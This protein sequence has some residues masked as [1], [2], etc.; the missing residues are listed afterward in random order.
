MTTDQPGYAAV[1]GPVLGSRGK[2]LVAR[3]IDW[4]VL[5]VVSTVLTWGQSQ[6]VNEL[7]A[8]YQ[9]SSDPMGLFSEPEFQGAMLVSTLV[10]LVLWVV[11]EGL[12]IRLRGAT[13]GKMVM[14]LRVEPLRG[15]QVGWGQSIGRVLVWYLP[16]YVTCF[17]WFVIDSLWCLWDPRKQT[18][19]DK[20][21]RTVVLASR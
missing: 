12:L 14:G 3:I 19:H 13:L 18:L 5:G 21:V 10:P 9:G 16:N 2:R 1:A 17:L 4:V 20:I 8:Q 6:R 15:G 7:S 11:Y